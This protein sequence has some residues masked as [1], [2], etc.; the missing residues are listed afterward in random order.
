MTTVLEPHDYDI[1][2]CPFDSAYDPLLRGLIFAVRHMSME[3]KSALD[4]S[5]GGQ[6][7]FDKILALIENCKYSIHDISRTEVDPN[8]NLPRF[9][10]PFELG[11]DLGCKRYGKRHHKQ[12]T[13]LLLDIERY[14]YRAFISDIAGFDIEEHNGSVAKA[15][16][17][18]R[19]WLRHTSD[20]IKFEV[21]SGG[22][23]YARYQAFQRYLPGACYD[24]NW[25][26][27]NL[28]FTDFSWAAHDWIKNNPI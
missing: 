2:N 3:P 15:I 7:R 23:I 27:D 8:H 5:D 18:V 10:V 28:P 17:V 6:P 13:T 11:L 16:T 1:I 12:K 4:S 9:N 20:T 26:V 19:N 25:D 22:V 24:L 21:P 14:R